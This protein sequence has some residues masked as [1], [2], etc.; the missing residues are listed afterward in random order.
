MVVIKWLDWRNDCKLLS[1]AGDSG[2]LFYYDIREDKLDTV[3]KEKQGK[4]KSDL[5][6]ALIQNCQGGIWSVKWSECGNFIAIASESGNAKVFDFRTQK[7]L[8]SQKSP[9]SKSF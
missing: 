4:P 7:C 6:Y 2:K 8:F 5:H 3:T 1:L 9:A